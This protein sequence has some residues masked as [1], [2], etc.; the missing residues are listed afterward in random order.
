MQLKRTDAT[1]RKAEQ[2]CAVSA[3]QLPITTTIFGGKD[4]TLLV[5]AAVYFPKEAL[6]MDQQEI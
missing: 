5:A 1:R 6:G 4:T 3:K 2:V